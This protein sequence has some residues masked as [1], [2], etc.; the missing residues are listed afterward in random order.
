MDDSSAYGIM[1][2]IYSICFMENIGLDNFNR[3]A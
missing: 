3:Y 2:P 1:V